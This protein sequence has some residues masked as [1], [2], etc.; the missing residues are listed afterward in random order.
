MIILVNSK[1]LEH[2]KAIISGLAAQK[3]GLVD[4]H[5]WQMKAI[6]ATLEGR[7][8]LIIQPTGSGKSLCFIIPPLHD[9]KTAIVISPTIS[10]MTD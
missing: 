6:T 4:L 1:I 2:Q 8:T 7:D 5:C 3:F 9:G 10:L